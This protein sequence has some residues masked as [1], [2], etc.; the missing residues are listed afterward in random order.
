MA[1]RT[2]PLGAQLGDLYR[3]HAEELLPARWAAFRR[4]PLDP[5]AVAM[6]MSADPETV[7]RLLGKSPDRRDTTR[8]LLLRIR[9]LSP[10]KFAA[11][12]LQ[13]HTATAALLVVGDVFP[14]GAWHVGPLVFVGAQ[15]AVG[16]SYLRAVQ[17]CSEG[18]LF[19][20]P[21]E[22]RYRT[23]RPVKTTGSLPRVMQIEFNR[24]LVGVFA[25]AAGEVCLWTVGAD[26]YRS[27]EAAKRFGGAGRFPLVFAPAKGFAP[28]PSST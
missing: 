20:E 18:D 6:L 5:R 15:R 25:T 10:D 24:R 23:G 26:E 11:E 16:H 9:E 8:F 13:E 1:Y 28:C 22:R 19:Q 2:T 4:D 3:Q 17:I 12:H 7:Y 21:A 27:P 14:H